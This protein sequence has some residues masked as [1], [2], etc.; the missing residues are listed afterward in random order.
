[1]KNNKPLIALFIV[2]LIIGIGGVLVYFISTFVVPNVFGTDPYRTKVTEVFTSPDNWEPGTT[3]PKTVFV[4]NNGSVDVAVRASITESWVG[5]SGNS[6]PLALS[7]D[8]RVS[9]IEYG[10]S[11][12]W[13]KEGN[14]YYYYT[15]LAPNEV[16]TQFIKSVTFN[17]DVKADTNCTTENDNGAS[18]ITC[19]STG[20]NYASATYTL[21][22]TVETIQ[23]DAY[24]A[25]WNPNLTIN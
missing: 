11:S 3:I 19:E 13:I 23:Y 18:V 16:T 20:D 12:Q 17:S 8:L 24:S 6:L 22:I 4:K 21:Y 5:S 25:V 9:I 10:D 1:M 14:Y 15:K 7:N 2:M